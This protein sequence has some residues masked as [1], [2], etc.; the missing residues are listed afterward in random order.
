MQCLA[1]VSWERTGPKGRGREG[2]NEEKRHTDSRKVT[3]EKQ[4]RKG[5]MEEGEENPFAMYF[6]LHAALNAICQKK[7]Q[8]RITFFISIS[9][10]EYGSE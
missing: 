2:E 4:K 6:P 7:G 1:N 3:L 10:A 5:R 9:H 8:E